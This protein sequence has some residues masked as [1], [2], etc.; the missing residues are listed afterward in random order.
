MP[1]VRYKLTLAY[2]GTAYCGWQRQPDPLPT[3][4]RAVEIAA[5]QIVNHP[6]VIAGSSRTDT[7]VHA[8]GQVAQ[9]DTECRLAPQRMRLAIN[10]RLPPDILIR[11]L[12]PAPSDFDVARAWRKR[13]R[14]LI[15]CDRERPLF[16]RHFVY[17]HWRK[18]DL[19]AMGDACRRLE[20]EHDF[21]AFCSRSPDGDRVRSTVRT[22]THCGIHSRGPMIIFSVEG[23]GFL[24]HMVR[25]MVGTVL[26]VGRARWKPE[27][28]TRILESA[29]RS[30]AGP[31][32]PA[33]GLCLQWIRFAAPEGS[34]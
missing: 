1:L 33:S 14:Y 20:G 16:Y 30:Q 22:I 31:C 19:A 5:G 3:V 34:N 12:V 29:D 28:I 9:M 21:A 13:Y 26:E 32:A 7:G 27:Q 10:S 23:N 11:E 2:D 24:Y 18:V 8:R 4:Q 6:V 15:W 25:T 17:H